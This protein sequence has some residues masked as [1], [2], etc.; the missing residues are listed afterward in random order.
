MVN[1]GQTLL[2]SDLNV[3]LQDYYLAFKNGFT[4][5]VQVLCESV[6]QRLFRSSCHPEVTGIV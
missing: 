2:G 5:P 4:A 1:K 6:K 3:K